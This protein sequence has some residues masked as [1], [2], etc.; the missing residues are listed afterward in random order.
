[1]KS[2]VDR[3]NCSYF[4]KRVKRSVKSKHKILL[5]NTSIFF[6]K[7]MSQHHTFNYVLRRKR[8]KFFLR[9]SYTTSLLCIDFS[10]LIIENESRCCFLRPWLFEKCCRFFEFY[11]P[12]NTILRERSTNYFIKIKALINAITPKHCKLPLHNK[13]IWIDE[14]NSVSSLKKFSLIFFKIFFWNF[15]HLE[16]IS[17]RVACIG[18]KRRNR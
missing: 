5:N 15:V 16:E 13:A 9:L 12:I 14:V 18:E 4:K 17:Y 8:M 11:I 1:M 6:I 7:I 10:C 2:P 3:V